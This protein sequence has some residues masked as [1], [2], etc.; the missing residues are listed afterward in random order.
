MQVVTS[1]WYG[2]TSFIPYVCYN[3]PASNGLGIAWKTD[4]GSWATLG[5]AAPIGGWKSAPTIG[6]VK[7][8]VTNALSGNGARAMRLTWSGNMTK[9]D[10][11]TEIYSLKDGGA[12]DWKFAQDKDDAIEPTLLFAMGDVSTYESFGAN[13]KLGGTGVKKSDI[14]NK[15]TTSFPTYDF[16]Y[17]P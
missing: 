6:Y 14:L 8:D 1:W 13:D 16:S 7:V 11:D 10:N 4:S 3:E 12:T 17:I 5:D 15:M 9:Y 2:Y